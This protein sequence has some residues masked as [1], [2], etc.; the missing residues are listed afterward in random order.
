MN[1][2]ADVLSRRMNHHRKELDASR[3]EIFR[4]SQ[5]VEDLKADKVILEARV[6][7]MSER[8]CRCSEGSPRTHSVG[9]GAAPL[10]LEGEELEYVTPPLTNSPAHKEVPSLVQGP[11]CFKRDFGLLTHG[12]SLAGS[13]ES[14]SNP[15]LESSGEEE[16]LR[17]A[18]LPGSVCGQRT[19]RGK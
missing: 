14:S 2:N 12:V 7:S 13:L 3:E 16:Q 17:D 6:D 18:P 5:E 1:G 4:L 19:I 8:L 11:P 10:E 15:L 9:S